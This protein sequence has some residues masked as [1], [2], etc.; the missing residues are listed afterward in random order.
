MAPDK[1][2]NPDMARANP[3]K[4]QAAGVSVAIEESKL[5]ANELYK[6]WMGDTNWS[7]E[8]NRL[9]ALARTNLETAAMYAV[10]AL[11]TEEP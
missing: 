5:K 1:N 11:T 3:W 2:G 9:F 7:A 6:L 10:K 4:P 8:K